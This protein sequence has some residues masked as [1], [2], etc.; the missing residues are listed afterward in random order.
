MDQHQ[1]GQAI[2]GSLYLL[3]FGLTLNTHLNIYLHNSGLIKLIPC[4]LPN[5]YPYKQ[6][7]VETDLYPI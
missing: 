3:Y 1:Y 4:D 6:T 7:I 2:H 5:L